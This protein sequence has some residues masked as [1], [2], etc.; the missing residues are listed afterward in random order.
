MAR[1]I[2]F[3][4]WDWAWSPSRLP[5]PWALD[6]R[7]DRPAPHSWVRRYGRSAVRPEVVAAR[8][9]APAVLDPGPVAS[10]CSELRALSMA[11]ISSGPIECDRRG[12]SNSLIGSEA[13]RL[14]DR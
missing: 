3:G 1:P 2:S 14:G 4:S 8:R 13:E 9:R 11:M 7:G 5:R 12:R 6:G 10:A